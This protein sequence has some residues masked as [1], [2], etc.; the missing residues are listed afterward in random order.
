M[1]LQDRLF[2][3]GVTR[4]RI[5]KNNLDDIF[6]RVDTVKDHEVDEKKQ[7]LNVRI[8]KQLLEDLIL[9]FTVNV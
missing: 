6:H 3:L 7:R 1:E 9:R 5:R 8:S 2:K 4:N